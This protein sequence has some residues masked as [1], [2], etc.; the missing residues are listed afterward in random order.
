[1][2]AEHLRAAAEAGA[3]AIHPGYGFLAESPD[4][5]QAVVDA[6]LIWVGPPAKALRLGGDK[7]AAKR[8]A[9]GRRAGRPGGSPRSSASR[10][11]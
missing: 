7:L 5:A 11:S 9:R 10:C 1:M 4:F 2:I 6:G 8:I 3:E